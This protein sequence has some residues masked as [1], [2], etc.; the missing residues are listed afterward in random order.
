MQI[1]RDCM[2]AVGNPDIDLIARTVSAILSERY[3][4][5]VVLKLKKGE[6]GEQHARKSDHQVRG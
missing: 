3:R 6:K 1:K 2:R 5:E 4:T